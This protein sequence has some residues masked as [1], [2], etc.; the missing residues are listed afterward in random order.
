ML[1]AVWSGTGIRFHTLPSRRSLRG[2]KTVRL[3]CDWLVVA[4]LVPPAVLGGVTLPLAVI[5]HELSEL[6]VIGSG[7]RM[8]RG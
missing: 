8:L 2:G 3:T 7:L 6:A 4:G 1:S 5:G